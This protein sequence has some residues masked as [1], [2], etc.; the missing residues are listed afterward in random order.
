MTLKNIALCHRTII[1]SSI[2]HLFHDLHEIPVNH[3]IDA[4]TF[5]YQQAQMPAVARIYDTLPLLF[6]GKP[7]DKIN[8]SLIQ[9]HKLMQNRQLVEPPGGEDSGSEVNHGVFNLS[10][11]ASPKE[12]ISQEL[13]RQYLKDKIQLRIWILKILQPIVIDKIL[14]EWKT[15]HPQLYSKTLFKWVKHENEGM[16]QAMKD[17]L[18]SNK[19][20][21]SILEYQLTQAISSEN[22]Q[23]STAECKSLAEDI[24]EEIF[25][26]PAALLDKDVEL[27]DDVILLQKMDS[28]NCTPNH[29][30]LHDKALC[31]LKHN[32]ASFWENDLSFVKSFLII[33][34]TFRNIAL[35]GKLLRH[36]TDIDIVYLESICQTFFD[37]FIQNQVMNQTQ[38]Q[39]LN[40]PE[41]SYANLQIESYLKDNEV[42]FISNVFTI[43]N[44]YGTDLT[45]ALEEDEAETAENINNQ[46]DSLYS[47]LLDLHFIKNALVVSDKWLQKL[48]G[49]STIVQ[50]PEHSDLKNIVFLTPYLANRII[51][52]AFLVPPSQWSETFSFFYTEFLSLLTDGPSQEYT[53]N[54]WKIQAYPSKIIE[55]LQWLQSMKSGTPT[56]FVYYFPLLHFPMSGQQLAKLM[57]VIRPEYL[58]VLTPHINNFFAKIG[59]IET[60]F[61]EFL[62]ANQKPI[63]YNNIK[64]HLLALMQTATLS[65]LTLFETLQEEQII[66]LAKELQQRG[67]FKKLITKKSDFL[68]MLLVSSFEIIYHNTKHEFD[69]VFWLN[70]PQDFQ[71]DPALF[72]TLFEHI[73]IETKEKYINFIKTIEDMVI[74]TSS[75]RGAKVYIK[76][77]RI[78]SHRSWDTLIHN[79]NDLG[80][81][82]Q[83][84]SN[85]DL[86]FLNSLDLPRIM[87]TKN[88]YLNLFSKAPQ[89]CLPELFKLFES[90]LP[91]HIFMLDRLYVIRDFTDLKKQT[92]HFWGLGGL[93]SSL[94]LESLL[95]KQ[96]DAVMP[97]LINTWEEFYSLKNHIPKTKASALLNTIKPKLNANISTLMEIN[98]AFKFLSKEEFIQLIRNEIESLRIQSYLE[99]VHDFLYLYDI[100]ANGEKKILFEWAKNTGQNVRYSQDNLPVPDK[101]RYTEAQ[102]QV[103]L[104]LKSTLP[105]PDKNSTDSPQFTVISKRSDHFFTSEERHKRKLG[106]VEEKEAK[107]QEMA[108]PSS[109]LDLS[110]LLDE[111]SEISQSKRLR[112]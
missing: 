74:I 15:K 106:E 95:L 1:N 30:E 39:A 71:G 66:D 96:L 88:D 68:Q 24:I 42:E 54:L 73:L 25:T 45:T 109:E 55:Q 93:N 41:I 28:K 82:L 32:I 38:L 5:L 81:A 46:I 64:P 99:T 77:D 40:M 2:N 112:K 97:E 90:H 50:E 59:D 37:N 11:F 63:F 107:E 52:H 103:L 85:F 33:E 100:I 105:A 3:A 9:L 80:L 86:D 72:T 101:Q 53:I 19:G 49:K 21:G 7:F 36:A 70:S 10:E 67:I 26:L 84:K 83:V 13:C 16:S 102:N 22:M 65:D 12:P 8:S 92:T 75:F 69:W 79:G 61:D 58:T 23:L 56:N 87:Q 111:E 47:R 78:F 91:P 94:K 35:H 89:A 20:K 14:N 27:L 6:T 34:R 51:L 43:F 104:Q 29:F 48:I 60:V 57:L 4:L 18:H 108:D 98:I 76:L 62:N 110:G 31:L 17:M 44:D